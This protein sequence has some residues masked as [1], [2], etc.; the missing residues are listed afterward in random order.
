M[1]E[2]KPK[3]KLKY[4][5]LI[6]E[7]LPESVS[8]YVIPRM[9]TEKIDRLMLKACHNNWLNSTAVNTDLAD[10]DMVNRSLCRLLN[11]LTDPTAPWLNDE[12]RSEQADICRVNLDELAEMMGKWIP[13]KLD[14][15]R[16]R[17]LPRSKLYRSGYLL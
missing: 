6:W 17:T 11:L 15:S 1:S 7:K 16:P 4:V 14:T 9:A 12:Y 13:Y 2:E 3:K 8:Y 5:T 10:R